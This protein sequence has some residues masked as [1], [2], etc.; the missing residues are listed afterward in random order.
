MMRVSRVMEDSAVL[1]LAKMT[2]RPKYAKK[3]RH[4]EAVPEVNKKPAT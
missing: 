3:K 4:S 2:V 1:N